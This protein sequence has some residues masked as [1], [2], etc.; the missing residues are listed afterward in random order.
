MDNSHNETL[1]LRVI[2]IVLRGIM[3]YEFE[4]TEV[5]FFDL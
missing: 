1:N 3:W 5:G 2:N 4:R